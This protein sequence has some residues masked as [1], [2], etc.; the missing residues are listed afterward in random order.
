MI[1]RFIIVIVLLVLVCGGIVGFNMFRANAIKQFFATMKQPVQ[2]VSTI[3]VKPQTWQPAIQAVGTVS[4][5]QGVDVAVETG[6][7]VTQINFKANQHVN[8][9][10]LLVQLNDEVERA[11]LASAQSALKLAEENLKRARELTARGVSATSNLDSAQSSETQAQSNVEKLKAVL[12]QKQLKAPF[13]GTI[14]IP[15]IDLGQYIAT[16]TAVATLQDLTK[17]RVD[18]TVPEQEFAN[19]RLGQAVKVGL[20]ERDLRYEGQI[21]GINPRIDPSSR[22]VSVR[23]EVDNPDKGLQPG[24]FVRVNV[25]LPVENNVIALPQTAVTTSLYGDYVFTVRHAPQDKAKEDA[26]S[27]SDKAGQA[28]KED[29]DLVVHQVFVELGRDDGQQVEIKKGVKAGDVVVT[30]GQNR[31]SNG[32]PARIDNS[33]NPATSHAPGEA[34]L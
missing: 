23:A 1:K 10:D 6:G 31:L 4:A 15:K 16:G 30:S 11:D 3:T 32:M 29:D 5:R 20:T 34:S 24:Q 9:G 19:L 7:T 21:I 26:S 12:D 25:E 28:K 14:G 22:L 33:V 17:M 2:T 18:F 8:K 27:G 13:S